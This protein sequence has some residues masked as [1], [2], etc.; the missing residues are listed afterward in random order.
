MAGGLEW[1]MEGRPGTCTA[2]DQPSSPR[3]GRGLAA[4]RSGA[5]WRY[6][7]CYTTRVKRASAEGS[8]LGGRV[9][10]VVHSGPRTFADGLSPLTAAVVGCGRDVLIG[11]GRISARMRMEI[12]DAGHSAC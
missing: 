5:S 6:I 11:I 8:L 10:G 7:Y 1:R 12:V 4:H 2:E 9:D 3:V